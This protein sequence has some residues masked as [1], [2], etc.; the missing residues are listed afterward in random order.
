M[1]IAKSSC[2]CSLKAALKILDSCRLA[3]FIEPGKE[4]F[5]HS[6]GSDLICDLGTNILKIRFARM[7]MPQHGLMLVIV[8]LNFCICYEDGRLKTCIYKP[9]H[10]DLPQEIAAEIWGCNAISF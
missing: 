7:L 3:L 9:E 1:H 4:Q 2:V 6:L 5:V 10:C 8:S